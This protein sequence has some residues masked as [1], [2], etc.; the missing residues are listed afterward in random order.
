MLVKVGV[1]AGGRRDQIFTEYRCET[2]CQASEQNTETCVNK[3][4]PEATPTNCLPRYS[5]DV[6]KYFFSERIV[7]IWNELSVD[8]DFFSIESFK[9]ALNGFNFNAYCDILILVLTVFCF[10]FMYSHVIALEA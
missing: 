4:V 5:T 6:H 9:R 10:V 8:T 2:L 1:L 7:K 3:H